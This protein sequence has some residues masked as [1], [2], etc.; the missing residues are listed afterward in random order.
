MKPLFIAGRVICGAISINTVSEAWQASCESSSSL[1]GTLNEVLVLRAG[2][3]VA[4]V[5]SRLNQISSAVG[6]R[7]ADAFADI[8][9][10]QW[11]L[12]AGHTTF[13][14]SLPGVLNGTDIERRPPIS[15]FTT[16]STYHNYCP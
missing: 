14:E 15:T 12:G 2:E 4:W 7:Q 11:E 9:Q 16:G 1:H 13:M 3:Q 10:Q 8:L 5:I 6:I